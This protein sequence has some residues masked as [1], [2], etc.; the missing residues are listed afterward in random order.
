MSQ[1]PHFVI[2]L[3]FASLQVV[4]NKASEVIIIIQ[5]C[6]HSF[7]SFI[8]I[9]SLLSGEICHLVSDPAH[10]VLI[11]SVATGLN[12][13]PDTHFHMFV[14]QRQERNKVVNEVSVNQGAVPKSTCEGKEVC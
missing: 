7:T 9:D 10:N 2:K 3:N 13:N 8:W 4:P 12:L 14:F 11:H 5:L 6:I 1:V